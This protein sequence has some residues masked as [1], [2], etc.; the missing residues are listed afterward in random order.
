MGEGKTLKVLML[1]FHYIESPLI[2]CHFLWFLTSAVGS[3][4][5]G[6]LGALSSY[7]CGQWMGAPLGANAESKAAC[8]GLR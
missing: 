6:S 5:I 2:L 1:K 8:L 4:A 7:R 3:G